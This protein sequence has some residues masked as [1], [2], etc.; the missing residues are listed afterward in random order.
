[1]SSVKQIKPD[2]MRIAAVSI[3]RSI[4]DPG[5]GSF[6][7]LYEKVG[8]N[9]G[10]LMFTEA[11]YSLI[12]GEVTQIGF[13]FDPKKVN[14]N[15]DCVVIPAANWLNRNANWDDLVKLLSDLKIPVIVIGI[16]LQA[17]SMSLDSVEISASSRR[18]IEYLRTSAPLIS[19]RGNFTR[20]WLRSIGIEN[21]VTT[22]C[23]SLYMNI[24]EQTKIPEDGDLIF[25]ATRY[26]MTQSFLARNGINRRLFEFS[27]QFNCP[28]IY[29]SEPEEME[30]ITSGDS[31]SS[32]S[33][34]TR[35][36]LTRL[37]KYEDSSDLEYFLR[38]R[39]KV[40][41]NLA[42]WSRFISQHKAVIGTRLHGSIIALNSG[43]RA[44]LIPHDSRTAEVASFAGIPHASGPTVK[45]MQT[46]EELEEL[47]QSSQIEAY[48]DRRS[49]NQIRF[50][51]F[52]R[53]VG[54]TPRHAAFF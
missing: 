21:V 24:F 20:D 29:Q 3:A 10:N 39:G 46:R 15:F 35:D 18:L 2:K 42:D 5:A 33:A 54:L 53:D 4:P 25:Q 45:D 48:R 27:G 14:T 38:T 19:V 34:E 11:I 50:K 36:L 49:Q 37:Y 1:M 30:L 26:E 47:V 23:P 17:D 52:L 7:S 9:T 32:L 8:K 16:G 51:E 13:S 40:F 12:E 44:V 43:R 41:Y 22:G 6:K 31:L 28:M